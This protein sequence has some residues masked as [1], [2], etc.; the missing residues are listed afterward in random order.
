MSFTTN[1]IQAEYLHSKCWTESTY[2]LLAK[3]FPH[4]SDSVVD[5]ETRDFLKNMEKFRNMPYYK[6]EGIY[7]SGPAGKLRSK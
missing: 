2:Y 6:K 7:I 3:E 4:W 5:S 1:Y